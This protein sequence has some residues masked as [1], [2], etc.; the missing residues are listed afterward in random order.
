MFVSPGD[1]KL[2]SRVLNTMKAGQRFLWSKGRRP[3]P[4]GERIPDRSEKSTG[5]NT[6]RPAT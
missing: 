6:R 2:L 4:Y 3:R 5:R 1:L